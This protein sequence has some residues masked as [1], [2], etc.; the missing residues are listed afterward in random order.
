MKHRNL[1]FIHL[2]QSFALLVALFSLPV[3]AQAQNEKPLESQEL[4]KLVYQLPQHPEKKAAVIE[5][6]RRRGI[7]F[8][9]TSGMRSVVAS[10]S[11]NDALLRR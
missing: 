3:A 10:K 11:G 5:E 8:E 1:K 4:V 7:A 6:I 2:L 9:L